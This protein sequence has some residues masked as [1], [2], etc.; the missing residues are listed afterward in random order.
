[1]VDDVSR[2]KHVSGLTYCEHNV[3]G[4]IN[5]CVDRAEAYSPEAA[6]HLEGG[7]LDSETLD[8]GAYVAGAALGIKYTNV[9]LL[10]CVGGVL[11]YLL[12]REIV[13]CRDLACDSVV[14]PE[15]GAVGHRLVVYLED[16]I[17]KLE[18]LGEGSSCGNAE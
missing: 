16:D 13:E 15:V 5:E 12:E 17:V 9:V 14:T 10:D 11:F 4:N 8:S 1:M 3:V 6:L 18:C 2:V 7:G